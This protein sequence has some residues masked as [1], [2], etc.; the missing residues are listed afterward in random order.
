M[1]NEIIPQKIQREIA[2]IVDEFNDEE[3]DL[4]NDFY[5]Y[6]AEFKGNYIYLNIKKNK[7]ISQS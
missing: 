3:L 6:I 7:S 2:K 5:K 4:I 1:K